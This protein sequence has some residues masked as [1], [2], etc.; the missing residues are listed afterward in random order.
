MNRFRQLLLA[1][2]I[3]VIIISIYG[4]LLA[5]SYS[6]YI[7]K[8][9]AQIASQKFKDAIKSLHKASKY[10]EKSP[11]VY[12]KIAECFEKLNLPDSAISYYEGAIVFNPKDI[13]A[14]Q[15]IGDI[16]YFQRDFHE[17]MTWYERGMDLG[18]LYPASYQKLGLIH[19]RWRE[20][21]RARD[22][23]EKAVEV[24]S[25]FADGYYGLGL[26]LM[27]AGDSTEAANNF[28]RSAQIGTQPKAA[29]YLGVIYY[30]RAQSDSASFWLNQYLK[31]EP[32]GEYSPKA[33]LLLSKIKSQS[34][35]RQ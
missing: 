17:A 5:G 3:T 11:E 8:A 35:K 10:N 29:Y 2:I 24:D 12:R 13:D 20:L 33:E 32:S 6:E 27:Q 30:A 19:L 21:K 16:N 18:R 4:P 28:A 7:K 22:Y 25:T 26:T 9:D 34:E 1:I 31:L 14:Y 15:K 23:F